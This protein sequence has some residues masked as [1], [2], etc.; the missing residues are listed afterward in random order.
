[1]ATN[2]NQKLGATL[3]FGADVWLNNTAFQAKSIAEFLKYEAARLF[4]SCGAAAVRDIVG[5][6]LG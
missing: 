6:A 2:T 5:A 4:F 3:G 1:L